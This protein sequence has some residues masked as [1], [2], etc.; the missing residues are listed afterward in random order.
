LDAGSEPPIIEP[1][2]SWTKEERERFYSLPRETQEYIA[3]REQERDREIR[4]SQNEAAEARKTTT[5]ERDR[6]EQ[7]RLYYESSL[8]TLLQSLQT[9][10]GLDF[11]DLKS[12][13]EIRQLAVTSPTRYAQWDAQQ[14]Q[15]AAVQNELA[16]AQQLRASENGTRYSAFVERERER[17]AEAAPEMADD[18]E[19]ARMRDGAASV[20]TEIGFSDEEL[21]RLWSG[22]MALP[23]HDHRVLLLI[24]DAIRLRDAQESV[25]DVHARPV[26]PVQRP[27]A[28]LPR[29]A[30]RDAHIQNLSKQLD[31]AHGMEALRLAAKL[32]AE[33]RRAAS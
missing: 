18:T 17:F 24:R 22:D 28:A 20:L 31:N 4:R 21:A 9:A 7:A 32:T 14:R 16:T 13:A 23:I 6:L 26:P 11:S 3:N 33:R 19:R 29:G 10:H 30:A 1:P 5:A 25:R 15:I 8:P 12:M 2:R 27:G